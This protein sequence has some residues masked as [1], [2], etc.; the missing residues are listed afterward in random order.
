MAG[1][2]I[3][4]VAILTVPMSPPGQSLRYQASAAA[5]GARLSVTVPGATV[6][7]QVIDGGG[8][9]AQAAV[10]SL[11]GPAPSPPSPTPANWPSSAPASVR[12]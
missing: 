10:D 12:P 5:D 3:V 1:C 6:V 8:P 11:A 2:R 4:G 9:T 7:D